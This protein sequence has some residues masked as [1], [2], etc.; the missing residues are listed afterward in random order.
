MRTLSFEQTGFGL[1][2]FVHDL[3]FGALDGGLGVGAALREGLRQHRLLCVRG[4]EIT[5]D[6]HVALA[7]SV[8]RP[9]MEPQGIISMVSNV[10]PHG[11]GGDELAWHSDFMFFPEPYEY[12]SL[13]A[14]QLPASGSQTR[15][16][17]AV[18]AARALPDRLR[19]AVAGL[20]GRAVADLSPARPRLQ[21]IRYLQGRCDGI[22][23]HFERPVLW[24]HP[25][26]GEE[27]LA[28][29]HQQTDA[30][31]PL[32]QQDSVAL[33]SEL[34]DHLYQPAFQYVHQW[35]LGDL[36]IW[37]NRAVQHSRPYVGSSEPRTLR[38]ISIGADQ[39]LSLFLKAG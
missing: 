6:Q 36:V 33:L 32:P 1:G 34:F 21:G 16:T 35:A 9:A 20:R 28:V 17:D 13:Y 8:G 11:L 7:S 22:D 3:D 37:D 25:D 31:L 30:L 24:P 26:T 5:D 15:F 29:W 10:L 4:R 14:L 2:A 23:P 38:R 27:V 39:D 19:T 12:I 18:A